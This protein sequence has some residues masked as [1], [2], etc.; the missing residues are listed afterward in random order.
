MSRTS[1]GCVCV[2]DCTCV[3]VCPYHTERSNVIHWCVCVCTLFMYVVH[4]NSTDGVYI[5]CEPFWN[6]F[7]VSELA[8]WDIHF[9]Q[10]ATRFTRPAGL[11]LL[12]GFCIC[13]YIC[14][15]ALITCAIITSRTLLPCNLTSRLWQFRWLLCVAV[16][17]SLPQLRLRDGYREAEE[18]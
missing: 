15:S 8:I 16:M 14:A 12:C 6:L 10:L 17:S 18:T 3:Y 13:S 1:Y 7:G 11:R 2:C 4:S 9:F 5:V